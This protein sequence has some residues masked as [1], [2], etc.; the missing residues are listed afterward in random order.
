M[1]QRGLDENELKG[2]ID[3]LRPSHV[4]NKHSQICISPQPPPRKPNTGR[5]FPRTPVER[6]EETLLICIS[7]L[8]FGVKMAKNPCIVHSEIVHPM[9]GHVKSTEMARHPCHLIWGVW[10]SRY[11]GRSNM[12][13]IGSALLADKLSQSKLITAWM[14]GANTEP[15]KRQIRFGDRA[16]CRRPPP[17]SP[18]GVLI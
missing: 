18:R 16:C 11:T 10:P 15:L 1:N 17:L 4:A 2:I 9:S 8:Q 13:P 7:P 14:G 5:T 6:N 3:G 12:A